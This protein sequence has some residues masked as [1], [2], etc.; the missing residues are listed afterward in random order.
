VNVVSPGHT[1]T[2]GVRASMPRDRREAAARELASR[3][4]LRPD[5][6]SSAIVYPCSDA[7]SGVNGVILHVDAGKLDAVD[8]SPSRP[9]EQNLIGPSRAN[10]L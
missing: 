6:V 8:Q 5:E 9:R 3:C 4:W 7:A 2:D 10:L 1:E